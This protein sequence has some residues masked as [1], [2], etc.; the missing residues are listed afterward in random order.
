MINTAA[1]QQPVVILEDPTINKV[2][3]MDEKQIEILETQ[4]YIKWVEEM[5][6]TL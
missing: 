5:G 3:N 2:Q 6:L 1:Q 4:L